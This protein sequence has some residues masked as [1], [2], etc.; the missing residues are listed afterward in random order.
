MLDKRIHSQPYDQKS[1][2]CVFR[3]PSAPATPTSAGGLIDQAGL[4]GYRVG[5]MEVSP[6][7]ANFFVNRGG[8][9]SEDLFKLVH[10]VRDEIARK[11]N[12]NLH[13]EIRKVDFEP[14][15]WW[16]NAVAR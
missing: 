7:H 10:H 13:L 14:K 9:T 3:N 2:G 5:A 12:V 15:S 8:G 11:F 4:K 6:L 1:A 16:V